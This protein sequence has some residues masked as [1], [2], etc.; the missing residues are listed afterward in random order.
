M[1]K[2]KEIALLKLMELKPKLMDKLIEALEINRFLITISCQKKDRP[3]D[4]ND[5]RHWWIIND[6]WLDKDTVPGT[7]THLSDD[8]KAKEQP[9][10]EIIG[11]RGFY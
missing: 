9:T 4:T 11:K 7:L 8:W 2:A 1:D 3:E 5:L 10:A 6:Y